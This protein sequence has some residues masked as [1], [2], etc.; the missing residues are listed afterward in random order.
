MTAQASLFETERNPLPVRSSDPV[1]SR[2]AAK[3]VHEAAR[4][5]EVLR[6]M[7]VIG[8]HCTASEIHARVLRDGGRMDIG[9]VRSRLVQLRKEKPPRTRVTGGVKVIPPPH[10]SGRQE[11]V[12]DLAEAG[13]EWLRDDS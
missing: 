2:A 12:W 10:G 3:S 1:T 6:A 5:A 13:R 8:A 4:K 7:A 9:S 11:Q